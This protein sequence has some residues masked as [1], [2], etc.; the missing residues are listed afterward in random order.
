MKLS[1]LRNLP[2]LHQGLTDDLK[3]ETASRRIWL[4]RMTKE[5]GMPYD[6]Q[7]TEE[8]FNKAKGRWETFT[9]YEAK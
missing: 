9:Q 7:V 8:R 6:N 5:D 3:K 2:T 4:S 1:T